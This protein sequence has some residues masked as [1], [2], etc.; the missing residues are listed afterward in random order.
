MAQIN[1]SSSKTK[2]EIIG[3]KTRENAAVYIYMILFQ[4]KHDETAFMYISEIPRRKYYCKIWIYMCAL[5]MT[6]SISLIRL[7]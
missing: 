6:S 7:F 2:G 3:Q 1:I 4:E 5:G